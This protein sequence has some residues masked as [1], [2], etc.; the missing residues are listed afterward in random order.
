MPSNTK[1]KPRALS[2]AARRSGNPV[3]TPVQRR[4]SEAELTRVISHIVAT[5]PPSRLFELYYWTQEPNLLALMRSLAGLS[6]ASR[7]ALD[8]FFRFAGDRAKVT[9]RLGPKGEVILEASH[10]T[11]AASVLADMADD[12]EQ[13]VATPKPH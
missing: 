13:A 9:A 3:R 10:T 4:L 12:D 5:V 8:S 2:G 11:G 7:N 1:T 6:P